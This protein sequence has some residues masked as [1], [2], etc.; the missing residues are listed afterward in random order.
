MNSFK[1]ICWVTFASLV[2]WFIERDERKREKKR[3]SAQDGKKKV[4]Q[5]HDIKLN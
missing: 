4:L 1:T 5:P 2:I 3:N